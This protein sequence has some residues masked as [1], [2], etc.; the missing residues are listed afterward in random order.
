MFKYLGSVLHKSGGRSAVAE[1]DAYETF[2]I[3]LSAWSILCDNK[4]I[5]L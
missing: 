4:I 3:K 1:E 5:L 2:S